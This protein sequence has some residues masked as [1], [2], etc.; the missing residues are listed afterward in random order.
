M[1]IFEYRCASCGKEFQTIVMPW[2]KEN[3]SCTSCGSRK[4]RKLISRTHYFRSEADILDNFDT[5]TP[6]GLD[7]YK[8]PK[9]IG[10]WAKKRAKEL[11]ADLGP[12]FDE[13]VER[14]RDGDLPLEP[15]EE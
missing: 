4:V 1:P 11:G 13:M 8:D 15:D 7:F 2:E 10:L 3:P 12:E 14:A 6:R 9:N 5:R